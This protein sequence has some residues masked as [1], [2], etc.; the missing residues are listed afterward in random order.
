MNSGLILRQHLYLRLAIFF[1]GIT[2]T[3]GASLRQMLLQSALCLLYFS[4]ESRLFAKL[5]FALRK[6]LSFLAAYW[7]F[8]LLFQLDF[9]DTIDFSL[10]IIYLIIITVAAWGAADKAQL[11]AQSSWCQRFKLGKI[12]IDFILAT[13]LFIHR[14]FEQY[15]KLAEQDSIAGIIERAMQAGK[16]VHAHSADIEKQIQEILKTEPQRVSGQFAANLLGLVFL[17]VLMVISNL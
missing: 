9:L 14:Y 1:L 13:Y 10:K 3:W 4:F 16:E 8:A 15:R 6:L 5:L 2:T 7:V 17:S 12:F 11:L